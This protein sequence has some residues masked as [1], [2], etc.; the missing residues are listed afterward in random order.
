MLKKISKLPRLNKNVIYYESTTKNDLFCS[1]KTKKK[2][3][4]NAA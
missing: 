4:S 2:K 1:Q 3:S